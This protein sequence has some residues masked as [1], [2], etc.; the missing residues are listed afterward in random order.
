MSGGFSTKYENEVEDAFPVDIDVDPSVGV[1]ATAGYR[2]HPNFAAEVQFEWL[3]EFEI[4]IQNTEIATI[5]TWTTTVNA[6]GFLATGRIQPFV[7]V[8]LGAF[9][10]ELQ[11]SLNL[12]FSVEE[13]DFAARF[14]GGLDIYAS[15]QIVLNL[16]LSYVLP[17]GDV[18]DL[19]YVSVGGGVTVRF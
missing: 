2:F 8:G 9:N 3:D 14:G 15:P 1:I 11:D 5:E 16:G 17:T 4:S 12:G 19:D 6:K 7:L 18:E 13:T 10:A